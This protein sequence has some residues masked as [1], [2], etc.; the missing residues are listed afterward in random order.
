VKQPEISIIVPVFNSSAY[1]KKCLD[2][3]LTQTFEDFELIL[4]DDGSPD[5]CGE[6][7]EEYAEKDNRII[8][9]HKKNGGQSS[10][11]NAG[12]DVAKGDYIGF[13]DSDDW[14]EPDMYE[15]LYDIC[16]VNNCD[17]ANCSSIIHYKERKVIN[18]GH[19]L[20][21]HNTKEAMKV[22]LW[23][24]LYDEVVWTKLIKKNIF[25]D[26]RFPEG[27]MYEDT[28]LTYKLIHKSTKI[29]CI[30]APKYN[31]LKRENSTMD[32]AIKNISIDRVII[33]E[34]MSK[35]M[36]IHYPEVNDIVALKLAN[37]S[38]V[39]LNLISKSDEFKKY[40]NNYYKVARILNRHFNE[41]I[42]LK[43]YPK[44]VKCLLTATKI[45]PFFYKFLVNN[46]SGSKY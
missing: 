31:Y 42:K 16:I 34:K 9:I 24:E 15:T 32:H 5:N 40:K 44:T 6:I 43:I 18:G 11:R 25:N 17:I 4:V 23:G 1:L 14:I 12:L 45:H 35:F 7:C 10:A 13:V 39:V 20:I 36:S 8:I 3:I 21:T 33:Y 22:M 30:G 46:F 19:S 37:S 29:C 28:A 38:M 26:L 41:T 2:S 27:I